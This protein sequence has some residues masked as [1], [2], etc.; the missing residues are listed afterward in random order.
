MGSKPP[1]SQGLR[2]SEGRSEPRSG[3]VRTGGG[4][5]LRP[6]LGEGR[7]F[8]RR[9]FQGSHSGTNF[10]LPKCRNF[11]EDDIYNAVKDLPPDAK[12]RFRF[13]TQ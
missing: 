1:E 3:L 7:S 6:S 11:G 2:P 12:V 13:V 9:S 5:E 4:Q 10:V 8:F